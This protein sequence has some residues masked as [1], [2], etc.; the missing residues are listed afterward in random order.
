MSF[1]TYKMQKL[2]NTVFYMVLSYQEQSYIF[3]H[4]MFR[5]NQ[6]IILFSINAP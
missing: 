1:G 6:I 2:K 5:Q 4:I 3:L